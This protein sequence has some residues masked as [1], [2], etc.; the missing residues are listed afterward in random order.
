MDTRLINNLVDHQSAS[1]KADHYQLKDESLVIDYSRRDFYK[2]WLICEN[3]KII[4]SGKE[5]QFDKPTLI[6]LHPLLPYTFL[7]NDKYTS[8]FWVIFTESYLKS[9]NREDNLLKTKLF[10]AEQP[11]VFFPENANLEIILFLFKQLVFEYQSESRLKSPIIQNYMNLLIYKG[12]AMD[13]LFIQIGDKTASSRITARFL[14]L[15]EK[16]YPITSANQPLVLK[17][18]KD[19]ADKLAVHVNHLN[20]AV[21]EITGKRTGHHIANRM[22]AESSVLLQFSNWSIADIAYGLGFNYPN[23]FNNFFKKHT[24]ATPLSLRK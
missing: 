6:F 9:I 5:I 14:E 8:G 19:F 24:G 20:A 1:F 2:I 12:L 16:Q 13:P 3:G 7:S 10:N 21:R 17:K 23:H 15:L 18:P 4:V 11:S 22:I